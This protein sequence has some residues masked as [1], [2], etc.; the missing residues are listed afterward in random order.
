MIIHIISC[1]LLLLSGVTWD[2]KGWGLVL[3]IIFYIVAVYNGFEAYRFY[4]MGLDSGAVVL[5]K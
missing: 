5:V 2:T 1:V 3:K 4:I